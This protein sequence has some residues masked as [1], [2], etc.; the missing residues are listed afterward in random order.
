MMRVD[1]S[2]N[3]ADP[4]MYVDYSADPDDVPE[5]TVTAVENG[6][7]VVTGPAVT[8]WR[9]EQT[10]RGNYTLSGRFT[11]SSRA[12]TGTSTV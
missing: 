7:Q 9:P 1:R 2:N 4:E 6:F 8:L 12:A 3:A 5:V 10:V 11:S